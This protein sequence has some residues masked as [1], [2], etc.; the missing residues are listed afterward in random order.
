MHLQWIDFV[1]I[2]A[3]D[4]FESAAA[5]V[6]VGNT[7]KRGQMPHECGQLRYM[8]DCGQR[9][10]KR[11]KRRKPLVGGGILLC[12]WGMP[13]RVQGGMQVYSYSLPY[14]PRSLCQTFGRTS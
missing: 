1:V 9:E 2:Y 4:G 3:T 14:R 7:C 6:F 13:Q 8:K 10:H 11:T 12:T 5:S